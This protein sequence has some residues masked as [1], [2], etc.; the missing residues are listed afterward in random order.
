MSKIAC[1][2]KSINKQLHLAM[3]ICVVIG[4][5]RLSCHD[6][7]S[8]CWCSEVC[9]F[10]YLFYHSQILNHCLTGV[11]SCPRVSEPGS[12]TPQPADS[13]APE[14]TTSHLYVP[15]NIYWHINAFVRRSLVVIIWAREFV[16]W[17]MLL[18]GSIQFSLFC[19]ERRCTY[20]ESRSQLSWSFNL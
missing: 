2:K 3:L 1:I 19:W 20:Q 16:S 9:M 6:C 11:K 15:I 4:P 12:L 17:V 18:A 14:S 5:R 8:F 7:L 10:A 13:L